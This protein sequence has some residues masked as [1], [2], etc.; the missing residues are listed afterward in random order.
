[1]RPWYERYFTADYWTY[2]ATEYTA[3][4]TAAEV[5]YLASVLGE[6]SGQ[7]VL[8]LGCGIGRHAVPL[9]RLGYEVTGVDVSAWALERARA[10]AVAAGVEVALHRLDALTTHEWPVSGVDAVVCVQ[11][12]GWGTDAAQLRL[13]R[14]L[15]RLLAPGGTLL[16]DHSN[17]SAI[18]RRYAPRSV[19]SVGGRTFEFERRYDPLSGRSGGLLRVRR[20][21]GSTIELPDDVRLYQPPEVA[22]LL[23]AAGFEVVRADADF[24]SGTAVTIDT[25]YVQFVARAPGTATGGDAT[26]FPERSR[27]WPVSALIGHAAAAAPIPGV[28]DLR[29]APDEARFVD[30]ALAAAWQAVGPGPERARRYDLDDPYGGVRCAPVLCEHFAIELAPEQVTA[31]A[32]ATGLLRALAGL[33]AGDTVLLDVLGHPEVALAAVELGGTARAV[34]LGQPQAA[35]HAVRT[36]GP[37]LT[38][39]DRPGVAGAVWPIEDVRALAEAAAGA[40]GILVVD[41]TCASYL[42]PEDS[43]VA[44]VRSTPGL[45]VVRSMSKGYSCGGLRV[46]FAVCSAGLAGR[47][48]AVC[49]PLGASALTLDLALALLRQGDALAGLQARISE[50]K[51]RFVTLLADAGLAVRAGDARLPWVTVDAAGSAAGTAAPA[52]GDT[53]RHDQ[54]RHDQ[55]RHGERRL[56]ELGVAGKPVPAAPGGPELVR[57]S[58]PL[59]EERW[60]S[61]RAALGQ[62]AG[63]G[64]TAAGPGP[65]PAGTR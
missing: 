25:R 5:G 36:A 41:E 14:A 62:R 59:S 42:P 3:A 27:P 31:G 55:R 65:G 9:A 47:V 40:G 18:L 51:P 21:D 24:Q 39:L 54:R 33:A 8:D 1:V 46:G 26:P 49:P 12:F 6:P 56:A 37:A 38:V 7:R 60:Q 53:Q 10:A 16:L 2:A 4:R 63:A 15:R 64:T 22:V 23:S 57:L 58:V 50:L 30:A 28:L 44:L 35:A 13:L 32:G 52:A 34:P 48:R 20:T 17:V 45:V 61:A 19:A 29:W 11:A 43:A